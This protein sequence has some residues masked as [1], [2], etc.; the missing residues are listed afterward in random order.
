MSQGPLLNYADVGPRKPFPWAA[1]W[2]LALAAVLLGMVAQINGRISHGHSGDFRHFYYASR[3]LLRSASSTPSAGAAQGR[4]DH[5]EIIVDDGDDPY[6]SGTG[7]YLYPPLIA[8]LYT[9]V[10][11]LSYTAAQR[12]MVVVDA[13][14]V[15]AGLLLASRAILDRFDA[16]RRASLWIGVALLACLADVDKVHNELQMFQT[17]ALQLWL[18]ALALYWLDRHP[19]WAG[20]PLG[21]ILNIKY[22]SLAMV[23]WLLI[24]RRWATAASTVL[25]GV[26]FALLPALVCG[27]HRDL[28]YLAVAYGGLGTMVGHGAG[29]TGPVEQA[30]VEDIFN[31]LSCS[32]TSAMAR[33]SRNLGLPLWVGM[34]GAGLILVAIVAAVLWRYGRRRVPAFAWPS[35]FGQLTQPWRAVLGMEFAAV[36]MASL[37]FSPQTNTRHLSLAVLLTT[38]AAALI[39]AGR[40][41]VVRGRLVVAMGVMFL[42]FVV[43][44]GRPWMAIGGPCWGVL[45]LLLTVIDSALLHARLLADPGPEPVEVPR[46]LPALVG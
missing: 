36:V 45:V 23:P 44:G 2:G 11:R 37:L 34:G 41:E 46:G 27:W 26:G 15:A 14:L 24:R 16:P 18:F 31:L 33:L 21:A 30:N 43:P 25:S 40:P 1:A 22:L 5:P 8:L 4:R 3:A 19:R 35:R 32:F 20:V 6:T 42:C 7:G 13:A 28:H 29:T 10:A 39:L 17:N 12:V 9:P 38:V